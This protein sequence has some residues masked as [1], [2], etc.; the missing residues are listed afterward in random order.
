MIQLSASQS[1]PQI[2]GEVAGGCG[3]GTFIDQ[4]PLSLAIWVRA[5]PLNDLKQTR[6][7]LSNKPK[8]HF[9]TNRIRIAFIDANIIQTA[10][11]CEKIPLYMRA[12]AYRWF[13]IKKTIIFWSYE[14]SW[15]RENVESW[16][17]YVKTFKSYNLSILY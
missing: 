13:V 2:A 5:V 4:W 3:V 17:V 8:C 12:S 16:L 7:C 1:T 9:T 15:V 14:F 10:I 11:K 6:V